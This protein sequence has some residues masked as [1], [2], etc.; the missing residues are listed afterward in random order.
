[1]GISF[2]DLREEYRR[3]ALLEQDVRDDPIEQFQDWLQQAI[4][5]GV[6]LPNAM[7]LATATR[8]GAPAVRY[9]LLKG[10]DQQGFSFY[11]HALSAKGR[12]L[13]E[14]PQ[15]ALAFY[16]SQMHRQVRVEGAAALLPEQ[17]ADA[18]FNT[19]P[20]ASRLA[21]WAADQGAPVADRASLDGRMAEVTAHYAGGPVPRPAAWVG[22]RVRPE[23]MEFWQGRENRLHDRLLYVRA[24]DAWRLSRLA[25]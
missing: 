15:A 4:E 25:P 13:A 8:D 16:W 20:R 10:L 6:P 14:N 5:F 11:T 18:Y 22:Y 23:R 7:A 12:Q 2:S 19:R 1:M 24:G 21:A 3:E 9:V 17:E